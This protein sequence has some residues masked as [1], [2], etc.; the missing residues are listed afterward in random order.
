MALQLRQWYRSGLVSQYVLFLACVLAVIGLLASRALVA[1]SPVVSIGAVVCNPDW[2]TAIPG[3]LRNRSAWWLAALY[4]MLLLSGLNTSNWLE[5]RHELFRQLP[6]LG[7]PLAFALAHPLTYTQRRSIG[8]LFVSA[9]ALVGLFTVIHYWQLPEPVLDDL[10]E[11]SDF[12]SVTGVFHIHFGLMLA[13]A[14]CIG[15]LMA[16]R[17]QRGSVYQWLLWSG[18]FMCLFVLHAL[19]YRTGLLAF[20]SAIL[21]NGAIQLIIHRRWFLGGTLLLVLTIG[22]ITLY[23]MSETISRRVH[24]SLYDLEQ[25]TRGYDIN[26]Y[27]LSQRIAAW[28]TALVVTRQQPVIG[29][30]PA[31]TY[32]AMMHQYSVHSYGLRPENWIMIHNQYLHFLVSNGLIGL[33]V[34]LLLLLGPLAQPALCRNPYVYNFLL[35]Q[36]VAMLVDSLLQLQISFNLFVFFYGFLLVAS[37]RRNQQIIKK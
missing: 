37:E 22:P 12:Q 28:E 5:W 18:A 9:T 6:L 15:I 21:V 27:S 23:H 36:G 32:D 17:S 4:A 20:Y 34:G 30:G 3:W 25:Y 7:V 2:R 33:A 13:L 14:S 16:R 29:V 1:L 11:N 24:T 35:I 31:D 26:D 19:V 8:L 10:H